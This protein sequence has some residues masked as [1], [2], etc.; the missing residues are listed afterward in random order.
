M[1]EDDRQK[2]NAYIRLLENPYASL[3]LFDDSTDSVAQEPTVEQKRAYLRKLENPH[4]HSS[5]F[6]PQEEMRRGLETTLDE[7]LQLYRPYI[8]RNEWSRVKE[9]RAVFIENA[10]A[11]AEKAERV[12]GHLKRLGFHLD[13]DENV[14]YNRAPAARIINELEKILNAC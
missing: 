4:A 1:I 6:D 8:A 7:V 2:A 10:T 5:I 14:E 3:S 12:M 13:P 9:Y 11:S